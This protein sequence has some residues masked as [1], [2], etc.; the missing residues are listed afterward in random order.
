MSVTTMQ[1]HT[2]LCQLTLLSPTLTEP[3]GDYGG[4]W[5]G[6]I[7]NH[8]SEAGYTLGEEKVTMNNRNFSKINNIYLQKF[9]RSF[10]VFVYNSPKLRFCEILFTY[11][12]MAITEIENTIFASHQE[13]ISTRG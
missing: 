3:S 11:I 7:L 8:S 12:A 10:A 13:A 1:T 6:H 5:R 2:V 4:D 9:L